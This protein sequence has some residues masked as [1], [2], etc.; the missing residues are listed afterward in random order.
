MTEPEIASVHSGFHI[1]MIVLKMQF[2]VLCPLFQ[3]CLL[4]TSPLIEGV[5]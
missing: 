3:S 1:F 4:Y 2:P 5:E